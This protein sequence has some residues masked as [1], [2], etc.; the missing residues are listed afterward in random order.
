MTYAIGID[1]GGTKTA[2]GLVT[3]SGTLVE[4]Q[5]LKTEISEPPRVMIDQMYEAVNVILKN[6]Q[7][8]VADLIGIGI[9][10]PGPLDVKKGEI[11]FSPNLPTWLGTPLVERVKAYFPLTRIRLENDANAAAVAE[12][13][14]GAAQNVDTF[15][16]LTISTG[17]GGGL[18]ADG[19]PVFGSTGNGGE[20]GHIIIDSNGPLCTC[21]LRGCFEAVAS[22]M[23]IA[24]LGSNLKGQALTTKDVFDLYE[25]GDAQMTTFVEDVFEK[26]G[27][28][29]VTLI[30]TFDPELIVLGGGVT[31][32][33][34]PLFDAVKAYTEKFAL[35]PVGR[36]TPIVP[37]GLDQDTGVIGAA[38]LIFAEKN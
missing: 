2:I 24:E 16:Y 28:G 26:I 17:I 10:A 22:G 36:H 29:C 9:G 13:W 3:D 20:V 6:N 35:T 25:A 5:I 21:G 34:K 18:Y 8:L 37:S 31:N 27:I 4:K 11:T 33:G 1:I 15:L 14:V 30:N 38:A 23:A 12:K 7:L 32:V 19:R